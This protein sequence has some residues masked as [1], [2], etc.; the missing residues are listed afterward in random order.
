VNNG[1]PGSDVFVDPSGRLGD[2]LG[3]VGLP[4]TFVLDRSGNVVGTLFGETSR[5]R[6]EAVLR[7]LGP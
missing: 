1:W 3:V 2:L 5:A 7:T 6:L 4:T